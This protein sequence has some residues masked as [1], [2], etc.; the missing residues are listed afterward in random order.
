MSCMH[1]NVKLNYFDQLVN[2]LSH[3]LTCLLTRSMISTFVILIN[4]KVD[5]L[6]QWDINRYTYCTV[7]R[8]FKCDIDRRA[9]VKLYAPVE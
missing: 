4:R 3:V 2:Q 6:I 8:L 9:L 7:D 5:W 1:D